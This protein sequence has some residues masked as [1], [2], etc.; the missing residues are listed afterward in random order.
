M[1]HTVVRSGNIAQSHYPEADGGQA[2]FSVMGK[3]IRAVEREVAGAAAGNT[4]VAA[5]IDVRSPAASI[6]VGE[7]AGQ[8]YSAQASSLHPVVMVLIE[9]PVAGDG[10]A[11]RIRYMQTVTSIVEGA[12]IMQA[13]ITGGHAADRD[14]SIAVH[15][16]A[17]GA[18]PG[19]GIYTG[20]ADGP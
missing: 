14:R 16:Q 5:I 4:R 13:V 2:G 12:V 7:Q 15:P 6:T 18:V 17:G 10:D 3:Y 8:R 11:D 1:R 9:D 20:E 19:K